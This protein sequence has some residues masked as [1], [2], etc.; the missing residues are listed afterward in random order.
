MPIY[1]DKERGCFVF[2]FDRRVN[3]QRVRTR[4]ALP[5]T[6]NQAQADAY[7]RQESAK[8]YAIATSVERAQHS[9]E[10]AV[11]VYIERRLPHLKTGQNVKRELAL[12]FFAY[13]GR[14][15]TPSGVS[16]ACRFYAAKAARDNEGIEAPLSA[17]SLRNRIRYLTAACRYAWKEHGMGHE[18]PASKVVV[19]TVRNERQE[20]ASRRDMIRLVLAIQNKTVRRAFRI[21]FYSGMRLSEL[22]KYKLS[23]EVFALADTKNGSPRMVPVHPRI[24]Y[25]ARVFDQSIPKITI[26]ANFRKARE[27]TGL[28]HLHLHDLRHSAASE[29]INA[30]VDLYTVGR[31]L[32]HKDSRSTQ[33]YAHLAIGTLTDAVAKIGKKRA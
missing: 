32:G 30:G 22:L 20:Y 6:W 12:M 13:Q 23:G 3:G 25:A 8:L 18:D 17:A 7:D 26:Q 28:D 4:K 16:D 9:I 31:V 33:R 19:P 2:E 5:K 24:K 11:A 10:D 21:L 1:R 15:L 29:L 27:R 14:P